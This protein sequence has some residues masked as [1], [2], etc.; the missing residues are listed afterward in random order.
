[1]NLSS[2]PTNKSW[3]IKINSSFP[4][5]TC[6][7]RAINFMNPVAQVVLE[8]TDFGAIFLGGQAADISKLDD[9]L[10][11]DLI[12]DTFFFPVVDLEKCLFQKTH[13]FDHLVVF[14][15]GPMILVHYPYLFCLVVGQMKP[16]LYP[17]IMA[18]ANGNF[19]KIN[20]I[21]DTPI[22]DMNH[23]Y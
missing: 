19:L 1:M 14:F 9:F 6:F 13:T 5:Q 23:D 7:S 20:T 21:G 8:S 17:I 4:F 22:F 15:G 18:V 11:T 2:K 16:T 12:R 3:T 10:Q